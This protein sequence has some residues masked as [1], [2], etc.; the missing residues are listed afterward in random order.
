MGII[1]LERLLGC[2]RKH[3]EFHVWY[4]KEKGW[5]VRADDGRF[6]IT[7]SGVDAVIENDILSQKDR[8]LPPADDPSPNSRN[9]EA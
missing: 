2:P 8:L 7:A 4:L 3:M 6:A 9:P 5:I 1:D